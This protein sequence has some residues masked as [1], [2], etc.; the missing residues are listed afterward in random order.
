M[1]DLIAAGKSKGS[2]GSVSGVVIEAPDGSLSGNGTII[3][4][5]DAYRVRPKDC[6]PIMRGIIF[7]QRTRA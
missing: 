5:A 7:G 2:G 1:K 4:S 3:A 6:A